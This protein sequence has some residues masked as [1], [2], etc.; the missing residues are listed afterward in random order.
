MRIGV[1]SLSPTIVYVHRIIYIINKIKFLFQKRTQSYERVHVLDHVEP[2]DK[3]EANFLWRYKQ[4]YD[5]YTMES[6]IFSKDIVRLSNQVI[7]SL[8]EIS[9]GDLKLPVHFINAYNKACKKISHGDVDYFKSNLQ[10]RQYVRDNLIKRGLIFV[11]PEN[12][13]AVYVTQKALN[14]NSL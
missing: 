1:S 9:S 7:D 11:S 2:V 4:Y 5:N 3:L 13:E 12:V 6:T 10:L 8:I 14:D